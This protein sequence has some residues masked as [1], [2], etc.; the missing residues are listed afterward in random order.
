MPEEKPD[1]PKVTVKATVQ[2]LV[3]IDVTD[4]W[5]GDCPMSQVYDQARRAAF[6]K[7]NSAMSGCQVAWQRVA[8]VG[9]PVVTAVAVEDRR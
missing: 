7:L 1:A 9:T 3:Q 4:S 6:N 5:G 8:V 2:L